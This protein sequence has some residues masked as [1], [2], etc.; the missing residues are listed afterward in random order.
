MEYAYI[1]SSSIIIQKEDAASDP[2]FIVNGVTA[3]TQVTVGASQKA[4]FCQARDN[5][6][7]SLSGTQYWNVI[8]TSI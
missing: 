2:D 3:Q 7:W 6:D 8:V 5:N 4:T 1:H